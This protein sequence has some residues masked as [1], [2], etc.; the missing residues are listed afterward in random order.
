[1]NGAAVANQNDPDGENE[2]NADDQM[3]N[4]LGEMA[5]MQQY[6]KMLAAAVNGG[7][8]PSDG[9]AADDEDGDDKSANKF[10]GLAKNADALAQVISVTFDLTTFCSPFF[11]EFQCL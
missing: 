11:C 5:A 6:N 3:M 8:A 9:G 7:K 10:L 4:D 2:M 1:M